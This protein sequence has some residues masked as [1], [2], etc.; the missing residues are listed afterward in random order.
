LIHGIL[1]ADN[2]GRDIFSQ[3]VYGSRISLAIGL[4]S[5]VIA[6]SLGVIIGVLAGYV[7]GAVDE[8]TMRVVDILIA[9][10]VLPLLLALVFLFG[11]NVVYIIVLI[12][13]F[14]WQGLSRVIRSQILTLREASFVECAR[15]S[16]ASKTYIMFKHLVPNVLPIAFASLVLSVPGAILTEASLSFLGFGDPKAATWGKMLQSAFGFG[17]FSNLAWWWILP[18][19]FLVGLFLLGFL[20]MGSSLDNL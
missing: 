17:A 20:L 7:G 1:G 18:P 5:A 3:L 11:P 6:T 8:I 9:L 2:E 14:G 16:G 13:I 12:A 19:I 10:P 4:L 15:A